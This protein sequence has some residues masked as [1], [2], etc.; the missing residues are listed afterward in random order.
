M[1]LKFGRE[2]VQGEIFVP[3]NMQATFYWKGKTEMLKSGVNKI[4]F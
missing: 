3:E 2:K 4:T 1:N